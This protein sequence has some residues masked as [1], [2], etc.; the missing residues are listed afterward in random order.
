MS[1]K[2]VHHLVLRSFLSLGSLGLSCITL[3]FSVHECLSMY[4][5][6][7]LYVCVGLQ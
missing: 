3:G 1:A 7:I 4:V 2:P 6:A 5:Y